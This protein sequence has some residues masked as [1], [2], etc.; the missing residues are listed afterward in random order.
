MGIY[1]KEGLLAEILDNPCTSMKGRL[2]IYTHINIHMCIH[3]Y[4]EGVRGFFERL[5]DLVMEANK[6]HDRP[7]AS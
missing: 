7:S 1:W 3:M 6:S 5:V 2:F 4:R